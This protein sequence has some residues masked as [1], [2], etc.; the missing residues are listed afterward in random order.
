MIFQKT[1][2]GSTIRIDSK[3]VLQTR[4]T[5]LRN[6][7][8]YNSTGT[9]SSFPIGFTRNGLPIGGQIIGPPLKEN[10]ILSVAYSFE[11]KNNTVN[12]FTPTICLNQKYN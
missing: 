2:C 3:T 7:I 6:T 4:E 5:L 1:T 9:S 12:K 10:L 8:V 11:H